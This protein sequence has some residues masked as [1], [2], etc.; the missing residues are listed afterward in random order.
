MVSK[1]KPPL[2]DI[3]PLVQF[4]FNMGE[5]VLDYINSQ[6]DLGVLINST[7]IELYRASPLTL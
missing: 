6:R 2:V 5:Q 4:Y 1:F 3:L 7:Y